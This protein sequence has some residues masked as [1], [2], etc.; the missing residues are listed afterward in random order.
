V[1]FGVVRQPTNAVAIDARQRH[2]HGDR[3]VAAEALLP[4][5][6]RQLSRTAA[7]QVRGRWR[8]VPQTR[9]FETASAPAPHRTKRLS[10]THLTINVSWNHP[11][12]GFCDI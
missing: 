11:A 2:L 7:H 9:V 3:R 8:C 5:R 6:V 12:A 1:P 4:N 10:S